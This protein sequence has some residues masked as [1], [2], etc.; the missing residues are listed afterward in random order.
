MLEPA[1]GRPVDVP[2]AGDPHLTDSVART[3]RVAIGAHDV[4]I[5]QP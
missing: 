4:R 3:D 1:R 5:Q 2:A